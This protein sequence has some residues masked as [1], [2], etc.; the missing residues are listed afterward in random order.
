MSECLIRDLNNWNDGLRVVKMNNTTNNNN[1]I[2]EY[3]KKLVR[4]IIIN[5]KKK[6]K[7]IALIVNAILGVISN[8]E[9]GLTLIRQYNRANKPKL[10]EFDIT[11]VFIT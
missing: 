11:N 8:P 10:S 5:E 2:G 3:D 9:E 4:L 6:K 1:E 7:R